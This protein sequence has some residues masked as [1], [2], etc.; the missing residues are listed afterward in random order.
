MTRLI[1]FTLL[2]S[3]SAH[4]SSVDT[5]SIYSTAMHRSYKCVVIKPDNYKS[6]KLNFPVIY[7]LHG[8]EGWYG[9]WISRVPQLKHYADQYNFIL[10]C[11]DGGNSSWYFDSPVDSSM[12]YET[13]IGK[14]VPDYIDSHYR[15]IKN[16]KG[17]AITGLSMGGHGAFFLAFRHPERFGACGSMS[18]GMNMNSNRTRFDVYKRLGDTIKQA[19]N[20]T[21]YSVLKVVEYYPEESLAIIMDCGSSDIFIKDNL[22]LHEKMVR[23][24]IP[25]DFIVRPGHHDWF[26]WRNAI[27]YQLLFFSIF[28]E[29]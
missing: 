16:R 27:R 26:Y 24:K 12:K 23:L 29:K 5:I 18:G 2:F 19:A 4:A 25:H 10:V 6:E 3:Y 13:Y 22:E 15:T 11:P 14:E 9:N 17:R 7:L 20:W 28:F 1:L 8:Y 21:N